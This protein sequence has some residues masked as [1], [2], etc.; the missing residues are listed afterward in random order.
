MKTSTT[1]GK[2][3][4]LLVDDEEC[5][6]NLLSKLLMMDNY[7]VILAENGKQALD[8]YKAN[9][10]LIDMVCMDIKMPIMDGIEAHRELRKF[11]PDVLILLMSGFSQEALDDTMSS[12]F[13]RKP[14]L[15]SELYHEIKRVLAA[16]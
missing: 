12:H 5:M 7:D 11:D 16:I 1:T 8:L 14:M 10:D 9:P 3:T 2:K 6:R 13:I 4:I 15:P